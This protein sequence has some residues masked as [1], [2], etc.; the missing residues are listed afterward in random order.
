M[1]YPYLIM[2]AQSYTNK[3]NELKP[4]K[5]WQ[6]DALGYLVIK[7]LI[8]KGKKIPGDPEN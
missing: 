3:K 8:W 1:N 5:D 7:H 2:E 4:L 6:K